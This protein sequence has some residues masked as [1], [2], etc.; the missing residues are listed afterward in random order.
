MTEALPICSN[1][2]HAASRSLDSV[3]PSAGPEVAISLDSVGPSAGPE[4]AISLDSVGPSAGPEVA[5]VHAAHAGAHLAPSPPPPLPFSRLLST[6][7]GARPTQ[8]RRCH[9][10]RRAATRER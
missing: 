6:P 1:Q 4:V 9:R 8:V 3:G 5:I 2:L 7:C 10:A